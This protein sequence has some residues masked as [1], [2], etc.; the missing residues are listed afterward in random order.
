MQ[1]SEK[2]FAKS[3]RFVRG[4]RVVLDEDLARIYGVPTWRLNE[5]VRRNRRRFPSD[6]AFQLTVLEW[7]DLISQ[8]AISSAQPEP[9]KGLEAEHRVPA[10]TRHGGRRTRPWA[11]T[12]HGALMAANVLRSARAVRMSVYVV[13][14][15]VRMR[16]RLQEDTS[17]LRRLA[18]IDATL[19]SHD[20]A[21][22]EMWREIRPLLAPPPEQPR[23]RIGF[24]VRDEAARAS[25][26]AR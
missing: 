9:E 2:A 4:R 5:A 19:F 8:F 10:P 12:E 25:P 14:A 11:Y 26:P 21:L 1:R 20:A 7:N 3:I 23:R 17:I 22:R 6:F 15:F 24:D 13:R 16:E 18:E